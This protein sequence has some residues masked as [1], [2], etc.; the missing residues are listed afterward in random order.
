MGELK[1]WINDDE[2]KEKEVMHGRMMSVVVLG[3]K[4]KKGACCPAC[5]AEMEAEQSRRKLPN[6]N[7]R[8]V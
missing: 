3:K 2:E 6:Y 4:D 1:G 7:R 8:K 5:A